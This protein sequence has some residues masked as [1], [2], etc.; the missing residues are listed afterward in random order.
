MSD[1]YPAG[2]HNYTGGNSP[3]ADDG[4][5]GYLEKLT[6]EKNEW[7]LKDTDG[8]IAFYKWMDEN[9]A[10]QTK[11]LFSLIQ[12]DA[13]DKDFSLDDICLSY[14]EVLTIL[15]DGLASM[16]YMWLSDL[17]EGF[18]EVLAHGTCEIIGGL[19]EECAEHLLAPKF[20]EI[21]AGRG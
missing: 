17:L 3:F 19:I 15:H 6:I 18:Y 11:I 10:I 21:E 8:H 20:K 16:D 2:A 7:L 14:D 9:E 4:R 1:Y 5:E 12:E 13:R